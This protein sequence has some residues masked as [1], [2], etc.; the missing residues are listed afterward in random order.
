MNTVY[1]IYPSTVDVGCPLFY[2]F[3]NTV[4]RYLLYVESLQIMTIHLLLLYK[5]CKH[6]ETRIMQSSFYNRGYN[7]LLV[8]SLLKKNHA[9]NNY[10]HFVAGADP[11]IL[12]RGAV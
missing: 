8:E 5:L 11:E 1:I 3:V 9:I 6:I 12:K 2:L 10:R 4:N 7:C